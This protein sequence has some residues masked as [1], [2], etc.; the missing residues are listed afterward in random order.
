MV[1]PFSL[2]SKSS[3]LFTK[4]FGIV[5]CIPITN[6]ITIVFFFF[7]GGTFVC[8]FILFF[9]F[10]SSGK[11]FALISLLAFFC[12]HSGVNFGRFSSFF[13]FNF[14]FFFFLPSIGVVV[15]PGFG[16]PFTFS[17]SQRI[18]CVSFSR[19]N[20]DLCLYHLVVWS[21]FNFLHSSQ[22]IAFPTH[23]CLVFYSF[24]Q[25]SGSVESPFQPSR[26]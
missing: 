26:V 1:S 18:L 13:L 2:I 7:W 12:F 14:F 19:A 15:K 16:N 4:L 25:S 20:S 21:N 23:S 6:C 10:F 8:L 24:A 22:W 3:S 11:D 5:P 9:F 17:K